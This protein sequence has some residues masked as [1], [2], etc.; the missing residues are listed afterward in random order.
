[1]PEFSP[2]RYQPIKGMSGYCVGSDGTIWSNRVIGLA[3]VYGEWKQINTYRRPYGSRY[4]V[5]C[6]RPSPGEAVCCRYV[7]RIVLESFVGE[8]PPNMV[9]CHYDGNGANNDI[10]NLRW[11]TRKENMADKKRH[12]TAYKTHC[13]SGLHLLVGNNVLYVNGRR[14]G[15]RACRTIARRN[16][17]R[18][19]MGHQMAAA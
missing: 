2:V 11:G 19:Q 16:R 13:K 9:C 14:R 3:G 6:F 1:M 5:V 4:I 7:H 12:G 15:C 17:L 8:C 10:T 18:R